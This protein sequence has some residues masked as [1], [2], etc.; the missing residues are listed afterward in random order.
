MTAPPA[1]LPP[2]LP[3][4]LPDLDDLEFWEHCNR[5]ELRIQ[6][7]T[8]CGHFRH[9]PMPTCPACRSMEFTWAE[10]AGTGTVFSYT[11]A[12][13]ATHPALRGFGPYNVVVVLLDGADDVRMV[14]NVVDVAPDELHIGMKVVLHWET[15]DDGATLPRW[16]RA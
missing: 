8:S 15:L 2:G 1:Y 9:T 12:H 13:H 4:P 6:H 14:G 10:V 3:P 5:R 7:C 16:R 11:I